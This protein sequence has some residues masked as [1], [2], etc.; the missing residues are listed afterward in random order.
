MVGFSPSQAAG[1][2]TPLVSK[3]TSPWSLLQRLSEQEV[4]KVSAGVSARHCHSS[5]HIMME[6]TSHHLAT[7]YSLEVSLQAQPI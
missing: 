6:M 1:Q 5:G 4:K 7:F 2:R 3:W